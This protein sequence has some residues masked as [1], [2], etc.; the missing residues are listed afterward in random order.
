M[1]LSLF[2]TFFQR[3]ETA[4]YSLNSSF[5]TE[6]CW[7]LLRISPKVLL[8][9]LTCGELSSDGILTDQNWRRTF[10]QDIVILWEFSLR[11]APGKHTD[12]KGLWCVFRPLKEFLT[13]FSRTNPIPIADGRPSL[14][15]HWDCCGEGSMCWFWL[16][17]PWANYMLSVP[18][19]MRRDGNLEK[20]M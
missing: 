6:R 20:R 16:L 5:A 19:K 1:S 9:I 4:S 14:R 2:F 18:S 12:P 13:E 8:E 7:L 15:S 3:A 17:E 10:N 11:N